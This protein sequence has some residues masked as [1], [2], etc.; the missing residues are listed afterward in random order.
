MRVK[1]LRVMLKQKLVPVSFENY[2]LNM[3]TYLIV[4]VSAHT[5][6]MYGFFW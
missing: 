6:R 1:V 5:K 3:L 2:D 4:S